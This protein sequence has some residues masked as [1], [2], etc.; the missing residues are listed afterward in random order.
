MFFDQTSVSHVLPELQRI[1]NTLSTE[2]PTDFGGNLQG[3]VEN[4]VQA[5]YFVGLREVSQ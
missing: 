5:L 2:A 4:R 1:A 3:F